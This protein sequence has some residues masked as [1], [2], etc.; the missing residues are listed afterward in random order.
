MADCPIIVGDPTLEMVANAYNNY[1]GFASN[2]Y[3]L[4]VKVL[5][6]LFSFV[7]PQVTTNTQYSLSE[8]LTGFNR[9]T[10]PTRPT[11]LVFK[12][13]TGVPPPPTAGYITPITPD[14]PPTYNVMSPTLAAL[15]P[16]G[17]LTATNPGAAPALTQPIVPTAPV[18]TLPTFPTLLSL[19]LPT[20]PTIT[21]PTFQGVRPIANFTAPANTFGFTPQQYSDALLGQVTSTIAGMLQGGTGLPSAVAQALRDRAYVAVDVQEMRAVQEATEEFSA[22]GFTE[23]NGMLVRR[24]LEVRQNNQNQR[25]SLSRDIYVQDE[26]IAIENLRFAVTQGVALES[27]LI[28][29]F[30]EYM[31]LSLD[32]AKTAIS[33]SI[34]VFNARVA[35]FN[36]Q[37]QSYQTDAQVFRDLIQAQLAEIEVYKAQL[38][39][40]R[41]IGELNTQ[42]VQIYSERVRALL[43]LVEVYKGQIAGVQAQAE[44]NREIIEGY[45]ATVQ[46]YAEQIRAY[47]A[48][49][50]GFKAQ[51][52]AN[53]AQARVYEIATDAYSARV[54]AWA[55]TQDVYIQNKQSQIAVADLNLRTWRGQLDAYIANI[56][57]ERD[58]IAAEVQVYGGDIDKYRADASVETAAA[59]SNN[60]QFALMMQQ[61][62]ARVNTAIKQAEAQIDQIDKTSALL[63]EAKS[64]IAK[65]S[66]QLAASA[67]SAVNFSAHGQSSLSQ[68]QTCGTETQFSYLGSAPPPS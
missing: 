42:N 4:S 15:T 58:R 17:N 49:W 14:L 22:R 24:L 26:Q 41:L 21:L 25:N 11:D 5:D 9:P 68:S 6:D 55:K 28:Q 29:A 12:L 57:A 34:D 13:N 31:R 35:L 1:S 60:R 66:A 16:P 36:S 67:M 18:I 46:A 47:E 50:E 33:I 44:V 45:R 32:A 54:G 61:E 65:V 19:N 59:E 64:T 7:V 51:V 27:Q 53:V 43:A 23:P 37:L 20:S 38:D 8:A 10:P 40:Q 30:T 52:D 39:G 2:A 48:Q 63:L 62:L 3:N 56:Q